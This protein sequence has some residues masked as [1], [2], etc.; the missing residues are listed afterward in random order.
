MMMD[1]QSA[2]AALLSED[3][4]ILERAFMEYRPFGVDE[5]GEK[6]T[7]VSGM[8]VLDNVELLQ[9]RRAGIDGA[10]AGVQVVEELCRLLN[11]RIRDSA[12]HVTPS[13]L[14]NVWNSYSYEFVSFL[15]E[16]CARLSG[17]PQF[18]FNVGRE[19]HISPLIQTLGRPFPVAQIY[20]MYPYF[21]EKYTKGS[22]EC[23]VGELTDHSAILRL[24]FTE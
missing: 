24:K 6:V 15:R 4:T 5:R 10:S 20:R 11:Q 18:H 2:H 13:F 23:S 22:I 19:K 3:H 21:A 16:F 1:E 7:D 14:K 9:E 8:I 12:Y 17:D